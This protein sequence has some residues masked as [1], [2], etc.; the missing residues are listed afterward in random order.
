MGERPLTPA[1]VKAMAARGAVARHPTKYHAWQKSIRF[2]DIAYH[3]TWCC[4]VAPD[5]R[6]NPD[7]SPRFPAGF[8]AICS[9]SRQADLRVDFEII[10]TAKGDT[11]LVVTAMELAKRLT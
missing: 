11:I 2:E 8:V 1:E 10:D 5:Q 6:L 7:G 4:H 9:W 3:L